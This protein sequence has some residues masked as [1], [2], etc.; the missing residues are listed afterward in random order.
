MSSQYTDEIYKINYYKQRIIES[1]SRSGIFPSDILIKERLDNINTALAI[2]QYTKN[3]EGAAFDTEKFNE[4]FRQIYDDLLILYKLAYQICIDDFEKIKSFTETHLLELEELARSYEYK[5]K[6]E[7]DSTSLGET[8]FFQAN[9][10]KIKQENGIATIDLGTIDANNGSKLACIFDCDTVN[11]EQVVFS[12]D[13]NNCTPYSYNKDFLRVPGEIFMK[14]YEYTI[15]DGAINNN[16]IEMFVDNFIPDNQ[17]KYIIYGG[18]NTISTILGTSR[19]FYNKVE[20][21]P[22]KVFGGGR[23]VFYVLGGTSISFD[24]SSQPIRTNFSGTRIDNLKKHHKIV[25]EYYGDFTF[26]YYTD[27]KVYG[28]RETGIIKDNKLYYP[29]A[30]SLADFLIEEYKKGNATTFKDVTVTVS[31]LFTGDPIKINTIAIKELS[32]LDGIEEQ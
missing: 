3:K 7:I 13:G 5:T 31:D 28:S 23:I 18:S 1:L 9:G 19:T 32:V 14:K 11:D 26:D 16:A 10:F 2:F 15:P 12:F 22:V 8:I 29:N 20:G 17:N 30:D 25:I 21:V 4:D 6:L 24:F 27:G